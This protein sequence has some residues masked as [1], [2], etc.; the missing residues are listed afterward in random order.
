MDAGADVVIAVL[1]AVVRSGLRDVAAAALT[2][3]Q[4]QAERARILVHLRLQLEFEALH[5]R[6]GGDAVLLEQ[7]RGETAFLEQRPQVLR[8]PAD[9][10]PV[11]G[12][13]RDGEELEQLPRDRRLIGG[14]PG[15][16]LRNPRRLRAHSRREHL[17]SEHKNENCNSEDHFVGSTTGGI[18]GIA[19]FS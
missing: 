15:A 18:R 8:V 19:G 11:G 10:G 9:V 13:V 3:R 16:D 1:P 4:Q 7:L 5:G 17:E 14:N 6:L 2:L 12:H